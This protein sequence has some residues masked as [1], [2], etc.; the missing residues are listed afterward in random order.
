MLSAAPIQ[1]R[2]QF[3]SLLND[4]GLT[5]AAVEVGT[6]RGDFAK[7]LLDTWK[8]TLHCVDP[9]SNPP[10]YQ[11][12]AK[13]LWGNGNREEDLVAAID[14]LNPHQGR[15]ILHRML[16]SEAIKLFVD[17]ELDFVHLD[18]NHEP[19]HVANDIENW[20]PKVRPDG[21]LAGHD[22]ICPNYGKDNWGRYIQPAVF[23]FFGNRNIYLVTE[24][25]GLP[26][27][28]YVIK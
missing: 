9:W 1:S 25:D 14:I 20:W 2:N 23:N 13:F 6:H 11:K 17:H 27:S 24:S 3:G 28:Y 5:N 21:I 22:F 12:Q 15:F 10:D 26:W 16:S 4:L 8:G 7:Q 18:G 19:P